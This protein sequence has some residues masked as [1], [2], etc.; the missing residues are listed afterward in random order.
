MVEKFITVKQMK[1]VLS[2]LND[3][4][5][6]VANAVG[7]ISIYDKNGNYLGFIDLLNAKLG[8]GDILNYIQNQP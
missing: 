5:Q 6:L 7:N 8:T 3:D 4:Y 1:V 2:K